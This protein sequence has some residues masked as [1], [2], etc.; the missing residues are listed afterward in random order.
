ML[1]LCPDVAKVPTQCVA[2]VPKDAA[3]VPLNIATLTILTYL[4][5]LLT[6]Y[7]YLLTYLLISDDYTP[8]RMFGSIEK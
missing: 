6:Y 7:T 5:H 4:L 1:Q 2:Y 3:N 8:Y